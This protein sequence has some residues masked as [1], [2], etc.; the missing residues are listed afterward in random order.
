MA[1]KIELKEQNRTIWNSRIVPENVDDLM[2]RIKAKH[3]IE[4]EDS[5][6]DDE[7]LI[8]NTGLKEITA[9]V[10]VNDTLI[11]AL[12]IAPSGI[13]YVFKSDM[14]EESFDFDWWLFALKNYRLILSNA[15]VKKK[16]V[17]FIGVENKDVKATLLQKGKVTEESDSMSLLELT[18][19]SYPAI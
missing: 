19:I 13:M 10:S 11:E 8:N 18:N 6:M 4:S 3:T 12:V 17:E 9:V 5:S 14:T 15:N 2:R 16:L 7:L 1:K